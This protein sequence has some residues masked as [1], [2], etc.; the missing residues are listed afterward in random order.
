LL[1]YMIKIKLD[2]PR[3][4]CVRVMVVVLCVSVVTLAATYM[5]LLDK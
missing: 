5:Y 4:V 3:H 2:K 1:Q